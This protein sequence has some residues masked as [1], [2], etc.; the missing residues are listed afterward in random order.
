MSWSHYLAYEATYWTS[1]LT[2][3]FGFSMRL[4]GRRHVPRQG[5]VLFI[6]NHQSFFDP[7]LVGLAVRRHICYLARQTLFLKPVFARAI[8][9]LNAVPIHQEGLGIEGLRTV[10]GLLE[11][12][13]PV[14]VFPEGT[15]TP[16]GALHELQVGIHLLIKRAR[17]PIVPVGIAGAFEAW[18]RSSPCPVPA[19]LFLPA[20]RG[21]IAVVVGRA[22]DGNRYA[23]L[24]RQQ[25]LADLHAA[26]REVHK[27]AEALRRR[28]PA[29]TA[30]SR[31]N[32]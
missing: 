24:P 20:G 29:P 21:T 12:G 26:L 14:L 4:Q 19:P 9:L 10:L 28:P 22:L 13:R 32:A 5:P 31:G 18:P 6:A 11:E 27:Q 30:S 7:I 2:M 8:R 23:E 25:V 3:V 1:T 15:R 16:D 17:V